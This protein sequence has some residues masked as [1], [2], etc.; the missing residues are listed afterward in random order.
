MINFRHNSWDLAFREPFGALPTGSLVT[1]KVYAENAANIKLRTYYQNTEHS[2]DMQP[3]DPE[4]D[5]YICKLPLPEQPDLLWYNF[6]FDSGGQTYNYGTQGDYLGGEGQIYESCPPSFQITLY[7]QSHEIPRWYT[8]GIMYQIFPDRFARGSTYKP[9]YFP[10]TMVHGCWSDSPHYVRDKYGSI[11][12]WDFFGGNLEGITE[13][14]DYLSSLHISILYL[15]PIFEGRSNHKYDTADYTRISPEFGDE[16]LFKTLCAE[17]EK[18]GIR[19]ILDGVF[20]HTGDDSIYFNRY[21]HYPAVGAYE[22]LDSPYHSWY[23][24]SEFPDA[25]ESWWGINCMPNVEELDT[26]YQDFIFEGPDSVIRHWVRAGASGWRL[27]VAD[28]LPDDFIV[29]LKRV[30][31]EEK[32]DAVLIGEVWEDASRKMAYNQHRRY[33]MG[34]ELD[35]VMNYPFRNTFIEFF[36]GQIDA[37]AVCRQMMALYE[38]YPRRQFMGNMNLIGSHDRTRILTLLG[39]PPTLSTEEE[40]EAFS[41]SAA[42]YELAVK[43]L[44]ALALLQ[45]TFPGVPCIYYGD[46]AGCQGFE[47]PFNRGTYPWGQ[48]DE[49][50]LTWYQSIT[51][52]R[53]EYEAFKC[54]RWYP[55]HSDPDIFAFVRSLEGDAFLCLFNRNKRVYIPFENPDLVRRL[56]ANLLTGETQSMNKIL[57]HPLEG[58]IFKLDGDDTPIR[59][60]LK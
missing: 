36:T 42:Q 11:D 53:T 30:L 25:Y 50:L 15:N 60:R 26:S 52:I 47:D 33:F 48:E 9:T 1:I 14:L 2:F 18:R 3:T 46:E 37:G 31:V 56:G 16:A 44:K 24:F 23:R 41:L 8:D 43:R 17:A 40:K 13:K 35:A 6:Q 51:T 59:P 58:V 22:S 54:G 27:D 10:H 5:I 57:L 45:M 49:E 38:H 21:G 12:Y 34:Q 39:N 20:S 28:E 29:G 32:P 7:E 4:S 55:L 19:I